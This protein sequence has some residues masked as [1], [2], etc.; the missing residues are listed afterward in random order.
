MGPSFT[1]ALRSRRSFLLSGLGV[2]AAC[3]SASSVKTADI[4]FGGEEASNPPDEESSTD[5]ETSTFDPAA[6]TP[7]PDPSRSP[8]EQVS[9]SYLDGTSGA[10]ADYTGLPLVINFFAS[11]CPPCRDELPHFEEIAQ[12][13]AGQVRFLGFSVTDDE[14]T[15]RKLLAETG[16]TF[17]VAMDPDQSIHFDLGGIAMP[18]TIFVD[19]FGN[20][21]TGRFGAIRRDDLEN[22]IIEEIL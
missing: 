13:Y 16:V 3:G 17:D 11:W 18:T 10:V 6:P 20:L 1:S 14:E 4:V 19:R 12:K 8:V 15:T 21:A 22:L 7:T 2:L 5:G 9:F